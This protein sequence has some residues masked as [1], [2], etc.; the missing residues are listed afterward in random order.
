MRLVV[1]L[2]LVS[3]M[4]LARGGGH[5]SSHTSSRSY[6]SS[7]HHSSGTKSDH[8]G[9]YTRKDGRYVHSYNRSASGTAVHYKRDHAAEGFALHSSV[10]RDKHGRIQRSSAAKGAFERSHPCPT[11]GRSSGRCSGYVVDHIRPLECGGA[12]DPSNMQWQTVAAAKLKDKGEH[13][14]RQ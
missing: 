12:D 3:G 14:C 5:Y 4:A 8:V 1:V 9:G 11:T 2:C 7:T 10:Q 13:T 6:H